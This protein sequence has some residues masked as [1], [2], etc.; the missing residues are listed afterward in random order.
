M[1]RTMAERATVRSTAAP[2][3]PRIHLQPTLS[4]HTLLDG[5]WW[6]RTTDPIAELPGLILALDRLRGPVTHVMLAAAEWDS[7]PRRLGIAHRVVRLGWFTSQP[8]GLLTAT[9]G[10]GKR[11]DLLVVP[12]TTPATA[13]ATAMATAAYATNTVHTPHILHNITHQ[14]PD[15]DTPAE[16]SWETEGGQLPT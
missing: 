3:V 4:H 13:A 1:V 9:T 5:G 14:P 8:R 15:T 12:P 10:N 16:N 7:H 6:P 2:T 11:V